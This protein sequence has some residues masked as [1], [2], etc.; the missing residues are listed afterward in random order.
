MLFHYNDFPRFWSKVGI[1]A[2]DECWP[3]QGAKSNT[4]YGQFSLGGK[5]VLAHRTAYELFVGPIPD[6]L[7]LDH[8]CRNRICANTKH[9]EPV[10]MAE[11]WARGES[12]SAINKRRTEC[13]RGHA[14]DEENTYTRPNGRRTCIPCRRM[15]ERER[16][17]R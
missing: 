2:P 1:G 7:T 8:L 11:N 12:T 3:W 16:R 17:A 13:Q 9:L 6:G 10:S 5:T 14:F 15:K 4:G